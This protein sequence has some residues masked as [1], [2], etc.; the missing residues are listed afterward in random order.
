MLESTDAVQAQ[1]ARLKRRYGL[2]LP[3]KVDRVEAAFAPLF[4][5]SR[6]QDACSAAYRQIHSLAGTSGTYGFPELG[7]CARSAEALVKQCLESQVTLDDSC[8]AELGAYVSRLRELA[9]E[10]ARQSA[11]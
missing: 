1:L 9:A 5:G 4:D 10:A 6:T 7:A 8:R 2:D 3:G 11:S